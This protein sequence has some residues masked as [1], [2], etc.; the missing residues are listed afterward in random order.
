MCLANCDGVQIIYRPRS[1]KR[2]SHSLV[3]EHMDSM[4]KA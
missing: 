4:G 1:G 2:K 3:G